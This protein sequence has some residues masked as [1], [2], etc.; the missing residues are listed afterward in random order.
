MREFFC[1]K[2]RKREEERTR[3]NKE[4]GQRR[5]E[6]GREGDR[7]GGRGRKRK[8]ERE[9]EEA[10]RSERERAQAREKERQTSQHDNLLW[11]A[12]ASRLLNIVV[13]FAKEPYKR[14]DI[15][16]NRLMNLW[17]LLIVATAYEMKQDQHDTKQN[18]M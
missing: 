16:Q 5:K 10:R 15:L 3:K 13:S 7:G 9:R 17:S 18:M 11:W 6:G 4:E 8:K 14:D 2:Q 12:S 1:E